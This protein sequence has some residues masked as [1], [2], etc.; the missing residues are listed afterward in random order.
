MNSSM[1]R[2]LFCH[3][4]NVDYS[5][6]LRLGWGLERGAVESVSKCLV[7]PLART[8]TPI[9]PRK[10]LKGIDTVWIHEGGGVPSCQ[11]S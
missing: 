3:C 7:G 5:H 10:F 8:K 4:L 2:L 11:A 9:N 1:F 6:N